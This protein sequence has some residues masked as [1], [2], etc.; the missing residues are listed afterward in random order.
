M[1]IPARSEETS[2]IPHPLENW[3]IPQY[4][5]RFITNT[6]KG[7]VSRTC[8]YTEYHVCDCDLNKLIQTLETA[9]NHTHTPLSLFYCRLSSKCSIVFEANASRPRCLPLFLLP[10]GCLLMQLMHLTYRLT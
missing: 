10:N 1:Q 5:I 3:L 8:G 2:L 6:D 9:K 7:T 4:S